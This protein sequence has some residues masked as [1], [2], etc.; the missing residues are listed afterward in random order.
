MMHPVNGSSEHATAY[1]KNYPKFNSLYVALGLQI[2]DAGYHIVADAAESIGKRMALTPSLWH[3]L[4]GYGLDDAFKEINT[5]MLDRRIDSYSSLLVINPTSGH[6]KWHLR[7]PLS[8]LITAHWAYEHNI[9]VSFSLAGSDLK[10]QHLIQCITKLGIWAPLSKD[11]WY[12]STPAS[13]K[14]VFQALLSVLDIGDQLCVFDS[15]GQI[16][17]WHNGSPATTA[18]ELA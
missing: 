6:A 13:S 7:Q 8:D 4:T 18:M 2:Q 12:L 14:N 10:Y 16:A 11:M 9:F 1:L 15:R 3:V 17:S 5:S